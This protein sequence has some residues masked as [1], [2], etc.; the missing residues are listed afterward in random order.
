MAEARSLP[1]ESRLMLPLQFYFLIYGPTFLVGALLLLAGSRDFAALFHAFSGMSSYFLTSEDVLVDLLLTLVSPALLFLGYRA[2]LKS[3]VPG[4][5]GTAPRTPLSHGLAWG[6]WTASFAA[7]LYSLSRAGAFG[8]ISAWFNYKEWIDA[9][10]LVFQTLGFL[11]FVNVYVFLPALTCLLVVLT[12]RRSDRAG[13]SIVRAGALC[14]PLLLVDALLFQKRYVVTSLLLVVFAFVLARSPGNAR[15]TRRWPLILAGGALVYVVYAAL[16]VL[17]AVSSRARDMTAGQIGPP[18]LGVP[19]SPGP[20]QEVT[21]RAGPPG[22]RATVRLPSWRR[23]VFASVLAV[24]PGRW[25]GSSGGESQGAISARPTGEIVLYALLAPAMRT[26]P[27][28]LAYPA[29]FP[30]LHPFFGLDVGADLAGWGWMPDDNLAVYRVLYNTDA[31]GAISVPFQFSLYSQAG[32]GATLLASYV[33]GFLTARGWRAWLE[34]SLPL[35]LFA[36]GGALGIMFCGYLAADS[37]RNSALASYG[38]AWGFAL[39]GVVAAANR[40][41][42]K[43]GRLS[44]G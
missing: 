3:H 25:V 6:V 39:L 1:V 18:V 43:K 22:A 28:A 24:L 26:P 41:I 40:A 19:A 4:R 36:S 44:I 9:R 10:F 38:I 27:P 2:G 32:I 13:K 31:E 20:P 34:S 16:V 30:R 21:G 14:A 23:R 12:W 35:P 33:V 5:A 29:I 42:N 37:I 17:L 8:H 7:A 11:E 15:A